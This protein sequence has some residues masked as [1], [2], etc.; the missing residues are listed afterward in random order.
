ME[1]APRD[2]FPAAA[3]DAEWE[4]Y[5]DYVLHRFREAELPGPPPPLQRWRD[6]L[7]TPPPAGERR[8]RVVEVEDRVVA[9]STLALVPG[10]PPRIDANSGV[11]REWRRRGIG[12]TWLAEAREWMASSGAGMVLAR[13]GERDGHGF[14]QKRGFEKIHVTRAARLDLPAIDPALLDRWIADLA[15]RAPGVVLE[16][17]ESPHQP[18]FLAELAPLVGA[19]ERMVP[20]ADLVPAE[21]DPTP[22]SLRLSIRRTIGEGGRHYVVVARE[23][24]GALS[25]MTDVGWRADDPAKAHQLLTGVLPTHRGRGLGKALKAR[26]LRHLGQ[27]RPE[28]ETLTTNNADG[29]AP[30][31]AINERLGFRR[32]MEITRYR[33]LAPDAPR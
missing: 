7:R 8:C 29:N 4:R 2:F 30:I 22:E 18:E 19:I 21:P 28:I 10:D 12:S 27:A 13:S 31:L 15:R 9:A 25:G 23:P 24:D 17:R 20:G 6:R 26:L 3:T 1:L 32:Q 5:H 16:V 14:L 33:L 11:L